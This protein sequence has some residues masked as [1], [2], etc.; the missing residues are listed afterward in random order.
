MLLLA[1]G[2][3]LSF[4]SIYPLSIWC[5]EFIKTARV[6][7]PTPIMVHASGGGREVLEFVFPGDPHP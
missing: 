4:L 6:P 5:C 7:P 1:F 3:F 2:R